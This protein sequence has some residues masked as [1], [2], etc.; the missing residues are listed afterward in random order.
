[1]ITSMCILFMIR[2]EILTKHIKTQLLAKNWTDLFSPFFLCI[3]TKKGGNPM[4]LKAM[5]EKLNAQIEQLAEAKLNGLET[6]AI[7]EQIETL[8]GEIKAYQEEI[9]ANTITISTN[10]E[11]EEIKMKTKTDLNAEL[12]KLTKEDGLVDVSNI[13]Y[14][15]NVVTSTANTD[16]GVNTQH[17]V[18]VNFVQGVIMDAQHNNYLL[19]QCRLIQ[20]ENEQRITIADFKGSMK[21]LNEMQE[22][23]FED[24]VTTETAV[25]L[26][27]YGAATMVS[28]H[29]INSANFNVTEHVGKVFSHSLALTCEELIAK[30]LDTDEALEAKKV[31]VKGDNII[32][33]IIGVLAKMPESL[34]SSAAIIMNPKDYAEMLQ[35]QDANGRNLVDFSYENSLRCK[36]C[37]VSVIVSEAVESVYV[38]SLRDAVVVGLNVR[39]IESEAL[40]RRDSVGMTINLFAGS[41][42]VLPSAV[43]KVVK[44]TKASK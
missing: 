16:L 29:L 7:E 14:R 12:R 23:E 20:T 1:M 5:K 21:R 40:P 35:L 27:R 30:A 28:R 18:P 11:G 42:V 13:E 43:V 15:A 41:K 22:I 10:T 31:T 37:G 34:R 44:A 3:L 24:F 25:T 17:A 8:R 4:N 39:S 36:I 2:L 9:R 26:E 33:T 6:R 38:G 32:N 19:Q